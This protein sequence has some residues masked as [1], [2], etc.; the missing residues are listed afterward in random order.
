[1]A[2]D[3]TNARELEAMGRD[4]AEAVAGAGSI[5]NVKV[6]RGEDSFDRPIYYFTYLIEQ[7]RVRQRLGLV[8][9]RIVQKLRDAL[10]ARQDPHYPMIR[11]LNRAD[12]DKG[13]GA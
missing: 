9:T 6:A 8:R 13:A 12:W 7:D 4:A 5:A 1:M 11:M 3:E 2:M 10:I